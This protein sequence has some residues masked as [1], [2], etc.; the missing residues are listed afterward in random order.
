[1]NPYFPIYFLIIQQQLTF[2]HKPKKINCLHKAPSLDKQAGNVWLA[3]RNSRHHCPSSSQPEWASNCFSFPI[4]L[5]KLGQ[6]RKC[7][8]SNKDE[9]GT[10]HSWIQ[11]VKSRPVR[12]RQQTQ[13][14]LVFCL[15]VC[16][17]F[18]I[19]RRARIHYPEYTFR[20]ILLCP[21]IHKTFLISRV[22]AP[23]LHKST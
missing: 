4:F 19:D 20:N 13:A 15:I 10:S 14:K 22:S 3:H 11:I 7:L 21:L 16:F 2:N 5:K 17:S 1:M 6:V 23:P 8:S 12:G 9:P 18:V